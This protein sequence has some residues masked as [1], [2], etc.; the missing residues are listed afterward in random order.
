MIVHDVRNS[1]IQWIDPQI[2]RFF[3]SPATLVL[4]SRTSAV[5]IQS[6]AKIIMGKFII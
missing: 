5:G 2:S 6:E 4:G 1:H 3:S